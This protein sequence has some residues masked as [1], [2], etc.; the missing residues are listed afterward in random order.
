M[1]CLTAELK[2]VAPNISR[3]EKRVYPNMSVTGGGRGWVN[4]SHDIHVTCLTAEL[5]GVAPNISH[6]KK[7]VSSNMSVTYI[8]MHCVPCGHGFTIDD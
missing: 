3:S 5:K 1:T 7:G 2:C 4:E 6:S 8:S